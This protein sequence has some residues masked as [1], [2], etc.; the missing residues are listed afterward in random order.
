MKYVKNID[1]AFDFVKGL[2]VAL[3]KKAESNIPSVMKL[4]KITTPSVANTY[5]ANAFKYGSS[6]YERDPKTIEEV[7]TKLISL[8][9]KAE[10]ERAKVLE[11][12][13]ANIPAIE[14]NL[15]VREKITQIMKDIGVP[16]N[17]STSEFKTQRSRT[18]TTTTHSAGYLG[19][20]QRNVP[21]SDEKDRMLTLI[22][23][24]EDTFKRHADT[25]K[26]TIRKELQD[27]EKTEKAKKEVLAKAR[28]QVKYNFDDDFEWS[29]VLE[30]L[31]SKDKYF[32]LARAMEDTRNDWNDGYGRVQYAI[33]GF[34]VVTE[35]DKE[36]FESI[37]ELAY[38]SEDIDGRVFRDCEYNYSFL[39]GKVSEEIMS[40]YETLK[41]YY[42]VY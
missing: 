39:Y 12:H 42:E 7:D 41:T 35:E 28:L 14:N 27:A 31:D 24:A 8:L 5:A 25:L 15:K 6:Y 19:D 13:Q 16:N 3:E 36:I 2:V 17:Y 11:E 18:K 32:K 20:L 30:V 9:A 21:V 37:H 23:S 33:R 10:Q 4:N 40:D 22:K 29:D 34:E 1:E 26:G 38:E